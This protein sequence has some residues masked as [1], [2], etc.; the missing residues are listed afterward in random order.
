MRVSTDPD[1]LGARADNLAKY[2]ADRDLAIKKNEKG[3]Y[4][5]G[6]FER[7][8]DQQRHDYAI[9]M[10]RAYA[11]FLE[12]ESKQAIAAAAEAARG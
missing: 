11:L 7:V 10:S 9:A 4:K 5:E 6:E 1:Y 3:E 2:E 8:R 12:R